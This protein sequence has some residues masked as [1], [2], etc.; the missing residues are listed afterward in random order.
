MAARAVDASGAI[1]MSGRATCKRALVKEKILCANVGARNLF[2]RLAMA[3]AGVELVDQLFGGVRDYGAGRVDR[4][5]ACF[6]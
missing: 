3:E 6:K 4:C 5:R 1:E 2:G